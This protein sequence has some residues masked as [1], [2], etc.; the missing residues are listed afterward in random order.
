MS[1]NVGFELL[2]AHVHRKFD[3]AHKTFAALSPTGP[4]VAAAVAALAIW[5]KDMRRKSR[6]PSAMSHPPAHEPPASS[7]ERAQRVAAEL[8]KLQEVVTDVVGEGPRTLQLLLA[9]EAGETFVLVL[10]CAVDLQLLH[11]IEAL[12]AVRTVPA[13][14]SFFQPRHKKCKYLLFTPSFEK[15]IYSSKF[16]LLSS[17]SHF[18][19]SCGCSGAFVACPRV[20]FA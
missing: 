6:K 8:L 19:F 5:E 3:L 17:F 12:P 16:G 10:I 7:S 13:I 11:V 18:L 14:I 2:L 1:A 9:D 4:F 15:A 20:Y